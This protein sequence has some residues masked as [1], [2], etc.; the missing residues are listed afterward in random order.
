MAF[1]SSLS[2][3]GRAKVQERAIGLGAALLIGLNL[4]PAITSVAALLEPIGAGFAL[5]AVQLSILA[6]LP[7]I[8]FGLTAPLGP[9]LA[10]RLGVVRALVWAMAAL[11]MSLILR[12]V[13]PGAMLAGTFVAGAAIMVA[14]TLL[15][16][17]LKSLGAGGLWVGLSS[18]SFSAGAALGAGLSVPVSHASG[19][20]L[21][22][23]V[24][25]VPALLATGAMIRVAS[26]SD[27]PS[28]TPARTRIT[29][30]TRRTVAL[31]T[32]MF[33]LQAM[34]FFAVAAWLPRLLGDRGVDQATA[35]WLLALA[36]IAG[37][38]PT[39]VAPMVARRRRVLLWFGPGLGAVMAIAF[40]WL[41]SGD[42]S[43]VI[44]TIVLGAVQ[45]A[46]FGLSLSLIV[47]QSQNQ[48]SAGLLSAVSQG[49]G[50]A[51]A[52]AGSLLVGI[53]HDLTGDW[54]P[55]LVF[56]IASAA[57]LSVIVALVIRRPAVDLREESAVAA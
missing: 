20:S 48:A 16:P 27:A 15:P 46:M 40:V 38:I 53:L 12:A 2:D 32:I 47:T 8:A 56:M 23:A 33:G 49:V 41:A 31:V 39:L 57:V 10:R 42:A 34:L 26:R 13:L 55:G 9:L 21:A 54:T 4:R 3:T 19:P 22:L 18:M 36:S 11:A 30:A 1:V 29:R 5:S 50:Y 17:Y 25:A 44:I 45:G 28:H 37:L 6:T 52:G 35:G 24:W 43:Y 14:G 7:V 51:F